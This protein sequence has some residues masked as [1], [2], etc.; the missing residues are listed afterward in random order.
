[1]ALP[2]RSEYLKDMIRKLMKMWPENRTV[3]VVCHGHS[4]PAG[5][6][7]TPFVDTFHAYP[8]LWHVALK[9]RFPFAVINM[10]VSAIGG[11]NSE[12]GAQRFGTEVLSHH[13]DLVTIDYG[14]NDRRI[15]LQRA[16]AAWR[17]M[18]DAARCADVKVMLLTPT[19]DEPSSLATCDAIQP[20]LLRHAE[21]IRRLAEETDVGL[22]DSFHAFDRAIHGGMDRLNLLSW[23]NHPNEHGH[24]LVV[25]ELM[26]W[27]PP[28]I[29]EQER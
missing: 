13:P 1:M 4:V 12:Q 8:H 24:G 6:F 22:V 29:A 9:R 20:P 10:I 17:A 27:F 23:T 25:E 2:D 18:I 15:G 21:A 14:L 16:M 5:Y 7:A 19:H 28:Y 26:R 11:E 3:N